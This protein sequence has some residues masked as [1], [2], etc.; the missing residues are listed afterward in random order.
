[1]SYRMLTI[2]VVPLLLMLLSIY[3]S[4]TNM[5]FHRDGDDYRMIGYRHLLDN[6]HG[7]RMVEVW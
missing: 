7:Y 4:I 1:M 5:V 3:P 2:H 6:I